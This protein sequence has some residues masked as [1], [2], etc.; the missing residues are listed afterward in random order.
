MIVATQVTGEANDK[1][2]VASAAEQAEQNPGDLPRRLSADAGHYS[3]PNVRLL[4]DVEVEVPTP[5]DR[6][7]HT[8]KV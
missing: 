4:Q 8:T 3:R 1:P 7:R 6:W 5:P 2:R